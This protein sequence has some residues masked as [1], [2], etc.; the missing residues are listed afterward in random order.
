MSNISSKLVQLYNL[1]DD[2]GELNNLEDS[3]PEKI[4][5]LVNL[6]AKAMADGRTTPGSQQTNEGWPFL[7][8]K[9]MEHFPQLK[10]PK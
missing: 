5:E 9:L 4:K 3:H 8:K 2:I 1:K 6:L 10:E 7:D